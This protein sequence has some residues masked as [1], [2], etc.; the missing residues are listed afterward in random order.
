VTLSAG[1]IIHSNGKSIIFTRD[2]L[3]RITQVTDP[4]GNAQTYT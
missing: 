1:G 3:G 2:S 4:N